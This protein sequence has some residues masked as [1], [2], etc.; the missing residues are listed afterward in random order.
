MPS[1]YTTSDLGEHLIAFS[2][3]SA[4]VDIELY[5]KDTNVAAV[6]SAGLDIGSS[7]TEAVTD[8][9][10]FRF[11][12]GCTAVPASCFLATSSNLKVDGVPYIFEGWNVTTSKAVYNS[13]E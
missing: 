3:R 2:S 9:V 6:A 13:V 4:P 10:S 1:I 8:S 12:I 11:R 5:K 7:T